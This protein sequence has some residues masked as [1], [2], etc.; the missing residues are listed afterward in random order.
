MLDY[1]FAKRLQTNSVSQYSGIIKNIVFPPTNDKL[2]GAGPSKIRDFPS[3]GVCQDGD[4]QL[5]QV[6]KK[7][8]CFTTILKVGTPPF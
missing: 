2:L 8:E 5:L 7:N 4:L 6:S 3:L 1:L